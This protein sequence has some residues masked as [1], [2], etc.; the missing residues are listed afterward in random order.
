MR[1]PVA[2]LGKRLLGLTVVFMGTARWLHLK[3]DPVPEASGYG[4]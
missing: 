4:T 1:C 3:L 2:V